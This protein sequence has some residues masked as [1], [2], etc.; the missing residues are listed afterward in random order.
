LL[1]DIYLLLSDPRGDKVYSN[2]LSYLNVVGTVWNTLQFLTRLDDA[3]QIIEDLPEES[4]PFK[5]SMECPFGQF[6]IKEEAAGKIRVFALVDSIT[7]SVMKP[8]H[9]GLFKILKQLP[10]DG[11]FDQDASVTRCTVKAKAANQAFSFDLSAATD[12]LPV[13]LTG[14]IIE[15]LFKIPG[16][17]DAWRK[18]M[19]ERDFSFTHHVKDKFDELKT[20]SNVFNYAV[21][22]PMG[23]LSS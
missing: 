8:L 19:V 7:Q 14:A 16:L 23:C 9:L 3:R 21:G 17:A 12:R 13:S 22:Q 11:T 6:A 20:H 4:L 18:V 2:I 15:S 10:N 5:K 1:S